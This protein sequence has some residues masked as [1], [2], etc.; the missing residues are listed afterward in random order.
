MGFGFNLIVLVTAGILRVP[1]QKFI[2]INFFGGIFWVGT[3]MTL[4]YFFGNLYL[5]IDQ[6][7]HIMYIFIG[8]LTF[9]ATLTLLSRY[10]RAQ[11]LKRNQ[12]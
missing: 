3:L 12:L 8:F 5:L 1:L 7:L 2:I 4:G 6:G 9:V 11:F 10:I